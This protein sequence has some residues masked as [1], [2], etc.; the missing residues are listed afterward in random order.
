MCRQKQ[1]CTPVKFPKEYTLVCVPCHC[2]QTSLSVSLFEPDTLSVSR[3]GEGLRKRFAVNF[4]FR[5]N[6]IGVYHIIY[7]SKILIPGNFLPD[8]NSSMAPPPV[9]TKLIF[10]VNLSA[11]KTSSVSPPPATVNTPFRETL[12]SIFA[13]AL[14]ASLY[15]GRS[16]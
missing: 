4:Y 12:A 3:M 5:K 15:G 7:F 10:L 8:K 16:K 9:E 1:Y 11:A 6:M 13:K 2:N 14:V